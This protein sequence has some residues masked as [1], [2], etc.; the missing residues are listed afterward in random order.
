MSNISRDFKCISEAYD[1]TVDFESAASA[2]GMTHQDFADLE[3]ERKFDEW[4]M[5]MGYHNDT[6]VAPMSHKMKEAFMAGVKSET[7]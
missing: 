7:P 3:L 1:E 6:E 5:S 4:F 2:K